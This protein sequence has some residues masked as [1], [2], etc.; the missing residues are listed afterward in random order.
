MTMRSRG[1]IFGGMKREATSEEGKMASEAKTV[2]FALPD[3][4]IVRIAW[5]LVRGAPYTDYQLAD[6]QMVMAVRAERT[7]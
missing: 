7:K 4:R 1:S 3:G 2:P 5:E 6:G